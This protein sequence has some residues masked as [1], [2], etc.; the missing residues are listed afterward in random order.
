MQD[1]FSNEVDIKKLKFT[2]RVRCQ[3]VCK[4]LQ[5][6]DK[7]IASREKKTLKNKNTLSK[8]CTSPKYL[9]QRVD[10]RLIS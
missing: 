7:Y 2:V 6:Y 3:R 10:M 9:L 4:L 1:P 5:K 8:I